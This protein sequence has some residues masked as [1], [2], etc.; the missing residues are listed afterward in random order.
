MHSPAARNQDRVLLA[1]LRHPERKLNIPAQVFCMS[2][3]ADFGFRG[4]HLERV[5]GRDLHTSDVSALEPL[6]DKLGLCLVP[7]GSGKAVRSPGNAV[8]MPWKVKEKQ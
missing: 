1:A 4:T 2:W 5:D 6:P 7:E 3:C 8:A